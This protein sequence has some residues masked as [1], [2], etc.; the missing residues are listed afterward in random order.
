MLHELGGA[1]SHG[2]IRVEPMEF[3]RLIQTEIWLYWKRA[4]HRDNRAC[5]SSLYPAATKLTVSLYVSGASQAIVTRS[6][7][8]IVLFPENDSLELLDAT[9]R[10]LVLPSE[11]SFFPHEKSRPCN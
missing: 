10:I 8:G 9:S 1:G 7:Y 11:S 2:V 4:Q 5:P 3:T 6:L